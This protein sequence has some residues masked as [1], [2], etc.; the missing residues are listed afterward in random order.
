MMGWWHQVRTW[1]LPTTARAAQQHVDTIEKTLAA[2]R[3][4]VAAL[5]AAER[6]AR[7]HEIQ[8][9][10]VAQARARAVLSDALDDRGER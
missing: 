4:E 6:V 9:L 3:A 7:A 5:P 10:L 1:L 2:L 8:T